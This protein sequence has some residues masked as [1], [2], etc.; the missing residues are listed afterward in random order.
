M[1]WEKSACDVHDKRDG[2]NR[3]ISKK[4]LPGRVGPLL[5]RPRK[6]A[7][8]A[9]IARVRKWPYSLENN[10]RPSTTPAEAAAQISN[11]PPN[12]SREKIAV[13]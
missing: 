10:T 2:L 7:A 4:K 11:E 12:R 8:Q 9:P 3:R 6:F 1:A 5:M 13:F